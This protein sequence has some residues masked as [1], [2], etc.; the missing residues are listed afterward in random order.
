MGGSK[1]HQLNEL[2]KEMWFWCI[3]KNI[4]LSAVHIAGK[5]NTS[6]NNRSRNFSDKH[7]WALNKSQFQEI[8]KVFPELDIDLFASRLKN[9]LHVYCSWKPDPGCTYV[10]AFTINWNS[11]N[12]FAFPPFSRISKCLQ[13]ITQDQAK[14]I[15][16]IPVWP[17]QPWFPLV[18]QLL[19]SQPWIIGPSPQLLTHAHIREPQ[20]STK[21]STTNGLSF[22]RDT[23][24]QQNISADITDILMASW[25]RGTQ[26]QYKT[27]V[28]K[29]LAFCSERKINNS[30]PKI[31][32]VLE[33][34]QYCPEIT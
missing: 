9:Q 18:L 23:F 5:L 15:L 31:S 14:G 4:W 22:I 28:E 24:T 32:E 10:D 6:A 11:L 16:I 1:S 7:E 19:Y 26:A 25:R 29:W 17:M 12:F 30:C 27:Y 13:R 3:E 34:I 20:P 2:A 33:F 21:G 8:A